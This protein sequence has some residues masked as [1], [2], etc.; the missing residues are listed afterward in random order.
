MVRVVL[1]EC[2]VIFFELG[3][4]NASPNGVGFLLGQK[5]AVFNHQLQESF[6]DLAHPV[7]IIFKSLMVSFGDV[8]SFIEFEPGNEKEGGSIEENEFVEEVL[9]GCVRFVDSLE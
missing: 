5:L 1:N 9:W 8:L 3:L 2:K 7:Y 4:P 6:R